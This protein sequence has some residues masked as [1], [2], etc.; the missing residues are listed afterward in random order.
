MLSMSSSLLLRS[1]NRRL[2]SVF[3][4]IG[5][6][7]LSGWWPA[8][9]MAQWDWNVSWDL[10]GSTALVLMLLGL[11]PG[12]AAFVA[13]IIAKNQI[14]ESLGLYAGKPIYL[15][16][17]WFLLPLLAAL[18][19]GLSVWWGLADWDWNMYEVLGG[20]SR[21]V[22]EGEAAWM[23]KFSPQGW[24]L[25]LALLLFGPI[26]WFLPAW[27]EE[28]AWRGWVYHQLRQRGFWVIVIATTLLAWL[29]KLPFY[30]HGYGYPDH[31]AWAP[32]L[33]LVFTFFISVILTWLRAASGGIL[34][35]AVARA[36]LTA[37]A[38]FPLSI[39]RYYSTTIAHF[40]GL[41]G[42]G[43][44]LTFIVF[45]W[46]LGW[47]KIEPQSNISQKIST[48]NTDKGTDGTD[49]KIKKKKKRKPTI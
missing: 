1:L 40:Q 38:A 2:A 15:L 13:L 32:V 18:A 23:H 47:F 48:D 43:V 21:R 34:A 5:L 4:F 16:P 22:H 46:Y 36:T 28:T 19:V 49:N 10:S 9:K 30:L 24:A 11:G 41:V 33:A 7:L 25:W 42:L 37:A 27:A 12:L 44:L 3:L 45:G 17:A 14:R 39:T 8:L 35:P 6:V 29:W 31:P 26:V 20:L